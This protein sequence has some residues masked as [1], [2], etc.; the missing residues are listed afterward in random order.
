VLILALTVALA[1]VLGVV[2]PPWLLGVPMLLGAVALVGRPT[3][4]TRAQRALTAVRTPISL[5]PA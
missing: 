4:R 5:Q 3:Y 1:A 2:H